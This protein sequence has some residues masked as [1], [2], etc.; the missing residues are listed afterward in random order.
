MFLRGLRLSTE[1]QIRKTQREERNGE[2]NSVRTLASHQPSLLT[3]TVHVHMCVCVCVCV[4]FPSGKHCSGLFCL[5]IRFGGE[6]GVEDLLKHC[7]MRYAV[8]H[9]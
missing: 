8:T 9:C 5:C 2:M 3:G 4:S 7:R 1:R 6:S